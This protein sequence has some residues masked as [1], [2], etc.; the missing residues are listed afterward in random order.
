MRG[1]VAAVGQGQLDRV[2]LRV[3]GGPERQ[4]G[5]ARQGQIPLALHGGDL[6]RAVQQARADRAG[7]G[8]LG[9]DHDRFRLRQRVGRQDARIG[10]VP[11]GQHHQPD[12]AID[13]RIGQI[14][15]LRAEG[16]D[17]G[18][19]RPIHPHRHKVVAGAQMVGQVGH[20]G[21]VAVGMGHDLHAVHPDHIVGHGPV[22]AQLHPAARP[23]L[24]PRDHALIGEG[25]LIEALVEIAQR[26]V[27]RVMRQR[28]RGAVQR[29]GRVGRA[30]GE[31]PAVVQSFDGPHD[32]HSA[33]LPSAWRQTGL[34]Q[35]CPSA[36]IWRTLSSFTS[37]PRPGPC[38]IA[39]KPSS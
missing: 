6:T 14:V 21:G 32:H 20:E 35:R 2:E 25:A 36:A 5:Q 30:F 24:V 4:A 17:G 19:L 39:T 7:G 23:C 27:H 13:P 10:Q 34:R 8:D 9:A 3:L 37:M 38:G 26:Q 18:V 1:H 11:F 29:R 16:R 15:D 31:D 22:K 28:D 33:K 12:I